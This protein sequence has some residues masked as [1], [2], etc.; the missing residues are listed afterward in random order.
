MGEG[1]V[2]TFYFFTETASAQ[3]GST[4]AGVIGDD[5]G[6]TFILRA[7]PEGGFAEAGVPEHGYFFGVDVFI[8]F[9]VVE[10][11]AQAPGPCSNRSSFVSGW[12]CLAL[13]VE[14]RL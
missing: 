4:A 12:F 8:A 2:D 13:A 7:G 5:N 3:G 11:P 9:E 14:D 1:G 10:S 6:K